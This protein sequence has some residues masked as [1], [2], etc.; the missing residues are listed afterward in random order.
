MRRFKDSFLK[1]KKFLRECAIILIVGVI[2]NSFCFLM[3]LV[4]HAESPT[5]YY[6]VTSNY[7]NFN[8]LSLEQ[9]FYKCNQIASYDYTDINYVIRVGD[10]STSSYPNARSYYVLLWD[11]A[12][13]DNPFYIEVSN[14]IYFEFHKVSNTPSTFAYRVYEFNDW[15]GDLSDTNINSVSYSSSLSDLNATSPLY[16]QTSDYIFNITINLNQPDNTIAPVLQYI[17]NPIDI[18]DFSDLPGIDEILNDIS[19]SWQPPS[20]T[21]HALPSSPTENPNNTPF[22]ERKEFFDYIANTIT[23][24]FS[25]L[26]SNLANWFNG[27]QQKLTNG[28]NSVSQ[29]IYNGFATLMSNIQNFFGLKLDAIINKLNYITEP[30]DQEE[31]NDFI[32]SSDIYSDVSNIQTT[33][34]TFTGSLI[35]VNEPSSYS[36]T[37]HI[38]DIGI[39]HQEQP[40]ILSFDILNDV[41]VYIRGFLWCFCTYGLFISI[42]DSFANYINGGGGE[43]D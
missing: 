27:L 11:K 2:V 4:V 8:V 41:K 36:I 12:L 26:G 5:N 43:D 18:G 13:N 33:V 23:Q 38:E 37:L 25:N 42:V 20:V 10:I 24:N 30:L 34:S 21:G 3:P 32:E 17:D 15:K 1:D 39:L 28:F 19:N 16:S 14:N 40:Y 31:I 29:N 35:G 9:I 7:N 22:Q 6:P